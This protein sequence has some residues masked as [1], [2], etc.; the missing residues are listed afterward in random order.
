MLRRIILVLSL[1]VLISTPT[2]SITVD[3]EYSVNSWGIFGLDYTC[4]SIS[5]E[6][7]A[8]KVA[9]NITGVHLNDK[10]NANVQALDMQY[11]SELTFIPSNFNVFFPNLIILEFYDCPINSIDGNELDGLGKLKALILMK[12]NISSIPRNFFAKT[13]NIEY[14]EVGESPLIEVGAHLFY[15]LQNLKYVDFWY[16]SCISATAST[17]AEILNLKSNL[18]TQCADDEL[19][20]KEGENLDR[21]CVL[22]NNDSN[23]HIVIAEYLKSQAELKAAYD[24][25]ISDNLALKSKVEGEKLKNSQI[26]SSIDSIVDNKN[27]NRLIIQTLTLQLEQLKISA[28]SCDCL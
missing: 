25:L 27:E 9:D 15:S 28:I 3:C 21:V 24:K 18:R 14:L 11:L 23:V 26:I 6:N 7:L 17:P 22:T 13:P 4:Y 19:Y 1:L 10:L 16:D 5:V 20:C 2:D 12:T 8:I